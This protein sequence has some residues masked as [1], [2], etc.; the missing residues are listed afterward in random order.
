VV[1]KRT[2]PIILLVVFPILLAAC[3]GASTHAQPAATAVV[4]GPGFRFDAPAGW[5]TTSSARAAEAG[6]DSSTRVSATVFNLLK[7]YR[8]ALF[9]A[10][11]QEL[12]R[13][14]AKLAQ[15]SRATLAESKTVTVAGRRIRA[16]RLTVHPA[17]GAAFDERIGFVLDGKREYQL[18]CRAPAGS[19]DP[20][21]GCALLY[22]TFTLAR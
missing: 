15:Q 16:Y 14:A 17:S 3:G 8:P 20:G 13:V 18:L 5:T 10:A 22:S 9:A 7:P 2:L 21:G 4:K 19:G 1:G 11:A 12:D 6:H